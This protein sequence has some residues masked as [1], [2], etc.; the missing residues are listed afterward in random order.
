[1][2]AYSAPFPDDRYKAGA[3]QFPMLVPTAPD[4]PAAADNRNAWKELR[5]WEKPF[6]TAFSDQDAITRGG[7]RAFQ[8]D[9]PGCAGQ[10]HTTIEGGGHFLQ[11]DQGEQLAR[12]VGSWLTGN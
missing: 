1:V 3:R 12:V 8:R 10:P 6:L 5:A 11:E 4:D 2:A 7:D 9:I